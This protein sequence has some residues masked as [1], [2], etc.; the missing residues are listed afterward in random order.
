M[1]SVEDLLVAAESIYKL[2]KDG[3]MER[4]IVREW[5][6]RLGDY[7]GPAGDRVREAVE[8]FRINDREPVS[9]E[10]VQTDL[11]RIGAI[12]GG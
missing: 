6:S 7:E 10:I 12:F 2:Y 1:N 9:E 3:R 4:D 11:D 5:I 8:W